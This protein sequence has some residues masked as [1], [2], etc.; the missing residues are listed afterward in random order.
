[1]LHFPPYRTKNIPENHI[2]PFKWALVWYKIIATVKM[3]ALHVI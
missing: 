3:K 2:Q 1:L